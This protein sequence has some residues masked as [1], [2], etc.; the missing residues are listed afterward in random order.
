MGAGSLSKELFNASLKLIPGGVNSPVRSFLGVDGEPLFMERGKGSKIYDADGKEYIDYVMSWGP[1]VFGHAHPEVLSK[2]QK[3][4]ERGTSFGACTGFELELAKLA[5]DAVASMEM[6]RFVNS[7]TEATMSA[8]RLARAVTD[9]KK[10][11]KFDGCYHGHVDSLLVQA[12][13][14]VATLGIASTPGIPEELA[15]L[16]ISIPYNDVEALRKVFQEQGPQLA[17]V[18]IEPVAGNM[19]V[20][21]PI[22]GYLSE[23]RDVCT[24]HGTILIFDEVMTGFRLAMGGAQ[25]VYGISPDLTCL[26]KIIGGGLPVGAYGGKK[27]LM[28]EIAPSGPVYQAGTLSGNPISMAAGI[29]T[30]K[31]L[32]EADTYGK[33]D[34]RTQYLTDEIQKRA[35][36]ANVP[37]TINRAGSMFTIFFQ[38]GPVRNYEDAKKSNQKHFA[39]YFHALLDEGVYIPPSQF[40]AWFMSLAHTDQDIEKTLLAHEKALKKL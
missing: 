27:E 35:D 28:Q 21:T 29:K 8:I 17:A 19:G 31:M 36:K 10:I 9:R 38:K 5:T 40:E 34:Y 22:E 13:S 39:K 1:L 11:L 7:G 26:G 18:I 25:E 16:T 32:R 14:G 6:I 30:L 33:L 15:S 4:L 12:G 3:A 20:V 37:V 2:I 24:K 23:L